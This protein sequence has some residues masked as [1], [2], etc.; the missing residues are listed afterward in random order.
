MSP[1]K[2][3]TI[4]GVVIA[5]AISALMIALFASILGVAGRGID[6]SSSP[7]IGHLVRMSL[8]QAALSTALSLGSGVGIAWSLNRL[9]FAGR[10]LIVSLFATAIVAPGLVVAFGLISVWGR[11]GW[12][13]GLVSWFGLS[14]NVNIFG[15]GGILFAHTILNG[16]FAARILLARLDGIAATKLKV[17][18][19][20]AL[21]P[22][23]RFYVLDWPAISAALPFLGAIIFLL[24]F[25]SF[26][27]I[28]LLGGGPANQTLEVAIYS[29]VRL[30]FDLASA[31]KLSLVQMLL[32]MVLVIPAIVATPLLASAGVAKS[33][34]WSDA[35]LARAVQIAVLILAVAGFGLPLLA[36]LADGLGPGFFAALSRPRL[37]QAVMTSLGIGSISAVLTL[38]VAL[39]LAMGRSSVNKGL[40]RAI[41]G[42]PVFAYLVIP[43]VVLSLG[44]FLAARHLGL[45]GPWVAPVVL[46]VANAL[47]AL[48]FGVSTLGP[49]LGAVNRRYSRLARAL[50]LNNWSRWRLV[51]WPLLG[52]EIGIVLA[53]GFG[54]SLGDL[55]VISLFGTNS[56][57]TLPWAMY[58]ALGAYRTNEAATIAA[59]MLILVLGVFWLLPG[60]FRRWADA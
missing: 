37:W 28:L 45:S 8:I 19:S 41:L 50:D 13:S 47:L 9:D 30:D 36:V 46:V 49:A 58:Q 1:G 53:L 16:A 27:I 48:P 57:V 31:V 5:L 7:D 26:P 25:T 22:L 18:Q 56:F 42:L 2:I 21:T 44:F 11:S 10:N 43:S 12:I 40:G 51:E 35:P 4:T 3:R 15:L 29:A 59:L 32:T 55:A 38:V 39:G 14:W 23:R 24:A 52:R 6:V 54:F 20:L 17:G 33:Q 34:A 60:L